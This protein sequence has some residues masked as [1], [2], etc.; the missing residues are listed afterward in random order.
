ME[1]LPPVE[2]LSGSEQDDKEQPEVIF[3]FLCRTFG[4]EFFLLRSDLGFKGNKRRPNCQETPPRNLKRPAASPA[5]KQKGKSQKKAE[6]KSRTSSGSKKKASPKKTPKAADKS[7]LGTP[8]QA[9]E[10]EAPASA[11][12]S[13]NKSG[14]AIMKRPAALRRPASLSP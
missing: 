12:D 1:I 14:K 5:A 6:S 13:A 11:S 2:A 7:P 4:H 10:S 8:P 9:E 3:Y